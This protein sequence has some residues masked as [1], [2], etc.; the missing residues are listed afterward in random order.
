MESQRNPALAPCPPSCQTCSPPPFSIRPLSDDSNSSTALS[1]DDL[2]P[3]FARA[4][5]HN[6]RRPG[7]RESGR[8]SLHQ[9]G[10][11]PAT[12]EQGIRLA[13]DRGSAHAAAS[14]PPPGP[15][16]AGHFRH[17]ADEHASRVDNRPNIPQAHPVLPARAALLG[18]L[19]LVCP[20]LPLSY[21]R[22]LRVPRKCPKIRPRP[23]TRPTAQL[24]TYPMQANALEEGSWLPLSFC[25][26]FVITGLLPSPIGEKG[27]TI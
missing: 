3:L 12:A 21:G 22:Q 13:V 14:A 9:T 16:L 25:Y 4:I 15:A 10:T 11:R 7:R 6:A 8:A 20:R 1:N 5:P 18:L 24:R 2:L 23:R 17:R 19:S 26:L 27:F